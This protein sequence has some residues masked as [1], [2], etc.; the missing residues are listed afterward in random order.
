M[1]VVNK[2]FQ[3]ALHGVSMKQVKFS[4]QSRSLRVFSSV[5]RTFFSLAGICGFLF[6]CFQVQK[7]AADDVYNFYFQ[8][9]GAPQQVIQGASGQTTKSASMDETKASDS[10][11]QR[12]PTP[13]SPIQEPPSQNTSQETSEVLTTSLDSPSYQR[14]GE[15]NRVSVLAGLSHIADAVGSG[16]AYTLGGQYNFN[17]YLAIRLQGH[18]LA[19]ENEVYEQPPADRNQK[20]NR[21]GGNFAFVFTPIHAQVLGHRF[22]DISAHAGVMSQRKFV[23][24][25][26]S[27]QE[28]GIQDIALVGKGFVGA[29]ALISLNE[30]FG[31]EAFA[32]LQ[33]GG[34]F[35]R[36]GGNLA[37]KF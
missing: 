35:N 6:G 12:S 16:Q 14:A 8:K 17:R 33:E 37:F 27:D 36:W 25:G 19:P 7:A 30:N 29:S 26:V 15:W 11:A 3:L 28:T 32:S 5:R 31:L 13:G 22:L 2:P 23:T 34:G 4:Y 18:F 1:E 24:T 10:P 9:G 20:V 21:W